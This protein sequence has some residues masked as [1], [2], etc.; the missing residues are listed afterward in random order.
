MTSRRNGARH[1][2]SVRKS[3][4]ALS[5]ES[6]EDL[7]R[8]VANGQGG[9]AERLIELA[10]SRGI[11]VQEHDLL[12]D[13]LSQASVGTTVSPETFRLV[14]EVVCFLYHTDRQWRAEHEFLAPAIAAP[15]E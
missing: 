7:P 3:A 4:V 5:Y 6:L 2:K 9:L 13:L 14:A 15:D 8:I 12:A 10:R 1:R 11:P